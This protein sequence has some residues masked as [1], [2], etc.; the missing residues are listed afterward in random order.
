MNIALDRPTLIHSS[1]ALT[2]LRIIL[3]HL[4]GLM[5]GFSLGQMTEDDF[6][7]CLVVSGRFVKE[8]SSCGK[9]KPFT[10]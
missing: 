5:H 6:S 9:E 8:Q 1:L 2:Y 7:S 10:Q 4:H 3:H